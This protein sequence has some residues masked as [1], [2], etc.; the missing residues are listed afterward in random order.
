MI[1]EPFRTLSIITNHYQIITNYYQIRK[2]EAV[3]YR[4]LLDETPLDGDEY[5]KIEAILDRLCDEEARDA[6][7]E[8][9]IYSRLEEWY[10]GHLNAMKDD[11]E[12]RLRDMRLFG[13]NSLVELYDRM[14]EAEATPASEWGPELRAF[15]ERFVT[16]TKYYEPFLGRGPEDY[17]FYEAGS[18]PGETIEA[19]I[20]WHGIPELEELFLDLAE[21]EKNL[22]FDDDKKAQQGLR[23]EK[24]G[25]VKEAHAVLKRMHNICSRV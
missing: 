24:A 13:V 11:A 20:R 4:A 1:A 15:M 18:D 8:R 14:D 21:V 2:E 17:A 3:K 25:I 7:K 9:E 5:E 6:E 12:E 10:A 16:V 19:P 23:K 22:A